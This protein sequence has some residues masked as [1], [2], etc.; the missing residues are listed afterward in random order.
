M[1]CEEDC[2]RDDCEC[3]DEDD[4][5]EKKG[6]IL[7]LFILDFLYVDGYQCWSSIALLLSVALPQLHSYILTSTVCT[8]RT[9]EQKTGI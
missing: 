4:S 2:R 6:G 7:V 3:D 8:S 1:N 9:G 5:S